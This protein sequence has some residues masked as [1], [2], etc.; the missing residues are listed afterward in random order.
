MSG[1]ILNQIPDQ[2]SN[3][4]ETL[5]LSAVTFSNAPEINGWCKKQLS[6]ID[7]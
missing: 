5:P 1:Q 2:I 6:S 7:L 4:I 3:Q